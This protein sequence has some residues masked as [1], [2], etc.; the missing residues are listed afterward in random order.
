MPSA[1][2][3]R[4]RRCCRC[5][6]LMFGLALTTRRLVDP[7]AV[8]LVLVALFFAGSTTGMFQPLR[9]DHHGWQLALLALAARRDR[10]SQARGA[11][12]RR[13]GWPARLSLAIGLEMLI[14]LALIGRRDGAVLGRRPR[15]AAAAGGLCGEPVA[16][17]TGAGFLALRVRRQSR[18]RCATPCRRCGSA[19]R[20]S[21]ALRCSPWRC[22]RCDRWTVRLALA[23]AAG[24]MLAGFHAL[25]W[26]HCLP[27]LEGVSP[28]ATELW[29]EPCARGAADLSPRLADRGADRWRCRSPGCSAGRCSALAARAGDRDLLRRTLGGRASGGDRAGAAVLADAH[30]PRGADDGAARRRRAGRS[31]SRR[32]PSSRSHAWLRVPGTVLRRAGRARRARC[33][34]S[35]SYFPDKTPR[36]RASKR[37]TSPTAAAR[38]LRALAAGR[39][40]AEG[41]DL[42]LRRPR[43]RG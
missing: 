14:Y 3:S 35:L 43:A 10:R 33:R 5:L 11:A 41:D 22:S 1:A 19:T 26:P 8:P 13:S 9:I 20:W 18:R 17:T 42:Q 25:A 15:P 24:A 30:R 37:S 31:S 40:P 23:V 38:R 29:L 2:A 36:R 34:W 7:R 39:A 12:G 4:S 6:L 21:A 16:A 32:W 27:R 28:E